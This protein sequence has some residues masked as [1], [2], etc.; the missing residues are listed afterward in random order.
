[1]FPFG[2]TFSAACHPASGFRTSCFCLGTSQAPFPESVSASPPSDEAPGAPGHLLPGA[3][4]PERGPTLQG[5][6]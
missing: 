2:F 5:E 6:W 1:M 4:G 3:Q